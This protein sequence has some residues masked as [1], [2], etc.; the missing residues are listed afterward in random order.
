M[1]RS[2]EAC[3][4]LQSRLLPR[5]GSLV[6]KVLR[7]AAAMHVGS[8]PE[9]M[10]VM[11]VY[12][13]RGHGPWFVVVVVVVVVAAAV[14]HGTSSSGSRFSCRCRRRFRVRRHSSCCPAETVEVAV[15]Q[16]WIGERLLNEFG[17]YLA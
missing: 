1:F 4:G 8:E 5:P 9:L 10:V 17:A 12:G 2:A 13:G 16:V 3:S 6:S 11:L 15:L 14:V 7:F